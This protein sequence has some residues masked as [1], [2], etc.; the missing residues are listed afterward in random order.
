MT[1]GRLDDVDTDDGL[2]TQEY[3]QAYGYCFLTEAGVCEVVYR[4]SS[5]GYYGG[6]LTVSQDEPTQKVEPLTEDW[7]AKHEEAGTAPNSD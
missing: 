2:C 4:N 6:Y 1:E 5:N 7:E 3:D